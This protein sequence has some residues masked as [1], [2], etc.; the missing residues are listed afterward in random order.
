MNLKNK[1]VILGVTGSI[2]AYKMAN[3]ASA[4]A[5][6][7]CDV[8]VIMTPNATEIIAPMTFSTL[9]GH[10]CIVDTFDKTINYNVAHVSLAKSADVLMIAPATANVIAKLAHGLADDMLT[11][12]A[13][14]CTCKKIV[15]PAMNTNMFHNPIVQDNIET[16]RR[17]GFEIVAPD[18]GVLACKDVGD[19]KLPKEEVLIDH[20]LREIACEK[21]LLGKKVLITA[22]PT[23]EAMDP[24]RFITN[25]SSG[26]MGYALA[27]NCMLRG[28]E[29]TLV[30]GPTALAPVPFVDNV[31][32]FSAQDMFDAV[33]SR[34]QDQDIIIKAAAVADYTPETYS[35][36][37]VKKK[38]GGAMSITMK[39]TP[40]ILA[41]LGEHRRPGQF[42]CGFSMETRDLLENSRAKLQR[43]NVDMIVAN[44]LKVA[45]AGF[46][47][48]TNVV[49]LITAEG[50]DP[51]PIQSKETLAAAIMDTILEKMS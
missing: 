9:T 23:C 27:K 26:K 13:L 31:A 47:G 38:E 17:Y 8:H 7:G 3:V 39:R 10:N 48:D 44:N 35:D 14:A 5:K 20:I 40:D 25:H 30:S 16:L 11:T 34:S 37:K 32:V 51:L 22:G 46:G 49:T 50:A 6:W 43:K 21:D 29:V 33:T 2:A 36:D 12:T 28:A 1:T 15:S 4:L 42:L 18:S 24:V 19:G 45:G 41:W